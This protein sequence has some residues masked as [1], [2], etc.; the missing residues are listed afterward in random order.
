M[1]LPWTTL[2]GPNLACT[3]LTAARSRRSTRPSIRRITVVY[4]ALPEHFTF[5]MLRN[6]Q[7]SNR[8]AENSTE[9]G[10]RRIRCA[11]PP[12]GDTRSHVPE[13]LHTAR[14]PARPLSGR[15]WL[16]SRL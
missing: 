11:S 10:N 6:R 3:R 1:R 16:L 13:V 12:S 8:M 9:C 14:D 2:R 15:S 4:F 5:L 7:R